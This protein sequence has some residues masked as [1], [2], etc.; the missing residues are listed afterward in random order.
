MLL[1]ART[2]APCE[3]HWKALGGSPKVRNLETNYGHWRILRRFQNQFTQ[4]R[5]RDSPFF[6]RSFCPILL[7]F[8]SPRHSS[9]HP[10][11]LHCTRVSRLVQFSTWACGG[12][13]ACCSD[14]VPDSG[15]S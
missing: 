8:F 9:H 5:S 7:L 6:V 2:G 3:K 4:R 1:Q 15:G 10:R 12:R 11:L 14:F 13:C